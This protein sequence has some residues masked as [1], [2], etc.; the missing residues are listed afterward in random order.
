[1]KKM[2]LL[3]LASITAAI[4]PAVRAQSSGG[5]FQQQPGAAQAGQAPPPPTSTSTVPPGVIIVDPQPP[6]PQPYVVIQPQP[7]A[8]AQPQPQATAWKS[9]NKPPAGED[10]E[11]EERPQ[12]SIKLEVGGAYRQLLGLTV[13]GGDFRFGV[14]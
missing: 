10:D 11:R 4:A 7:T 12:P 5:W 6:P 14:G 9:T 8:Q 2:P 3:V 1:M 13:A